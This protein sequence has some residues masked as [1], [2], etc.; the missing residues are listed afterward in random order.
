[1]SEKRALLRP[2][3]EHLLAQPWQGRGALEVRQRLNHLRRL[4]LLDGL[5]AMTTEERT[6]QGNL[7][8]RGRIWTLLLLVKGTSAADYITLINQGPSAVH[9]KIDNDAF[10]TFASDKQFTSRV[11]KDQIIRVLSAT[12]Q[13]S[14]R[15]RPKKL[16]VPIT[17]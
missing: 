6:V 7:S 1:M 12:A 15:T 4:I 14:R 17:S 16:L 5:P 8:L 9:D 13:Q 11:S 2:K 10:R 3:Y